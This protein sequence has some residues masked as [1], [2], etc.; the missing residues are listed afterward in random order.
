MARS[1][2]AFNGERTDPLTGCQPLGNGYRAY[3]PVLCRFTSCDDWSPFGA[4]GLNRYAYS[5][6]DPTNGADPSGHMGWMTGVSIGLGIVGMLCSIVT[7]GTSLA[8]AG[9]LGIALTATTLSLVADVSAIGSVAT[10]D[11]HSRTSSLLSWLSLAA[12]MLSFGISMGPGLARLAGKL[13]R[14]LGQG[15]LSSLSFLNK[16]ERRGSRLGIPLSGE[17]QNPRFLGRFSHNGQMHWSFR[18]EDTIPLGR[19]LNIVMGSVLQGAYFQA[20][21]D[22]MMNNHWVHQ[23]FT[24]SRLRRFVLRN[25]E[26]FDVFRLVIPESSSVLGPGQE[27]MASRFNT[28]LNTRPAVAGYIGNPVWGGRIA[29]HLQDVFELADQLDQAGYGYVWAE[30][31]AQGTLDRLA[32]QYANASDALMMGGNIR[33]YPACRRNQIAMEN[34]L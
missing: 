22:I 18:Y 4:G 19:R 27:A 2:A 8:V 24:P 3:S 21:C 34:Y 31:G 13:N 11:G 15:L 26:I 23:V 12:G 30:G 25:E 1:I 7:V 28:V 16:I 33:L 29:G 10:S 9:S 14:S 32:L 6:G 20:Q 5:E 17:F